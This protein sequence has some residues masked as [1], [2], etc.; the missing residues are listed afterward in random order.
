MIELAVF[1]VAGTTVDEGGIVYR[2]LADSVRALGADPTPTQI[3]AWM[4]A[5]KREAIA[6]LLG[7]SGV[8]VTDEAVDAGF[9]D[10]RDRLTAAYRAQPPA[11]FP[12]VPEL[13]ANLRSSRVKV[14]LTTGFDREVTTSL[15]TALGWDTDVVDAV[16]CIDDVPAGRPAPYMIFRAM[17][18]TGVADVRRTLVA[19][20]T[21]RDIRAG[22]NAGAAVVLAVLTGD[23]SAETLAAAE[24]TEVLADVAELPGFLGRRGQPVGVV[25]G[26]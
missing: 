23:V 26:L 1:D 19:G 16:V 4:G 8:D 24:P 21:V 15:L 25:V 13:I 14:A 10:F 11:P 3:E 22:H 12:G 2:V 9:A 6:A 17:E 7:E 20:D 18:M 5:G